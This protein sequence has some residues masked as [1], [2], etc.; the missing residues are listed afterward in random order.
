MKTARR[1]RRILA[2]SYITIFQYL[3]FL[4]G[5]PFKKGESRLVWRNRCVSDWASKS[6]RWLG[7]KI[8]VEGN[9]PEAPFFLV[10]NHLSYIDVVPLYKHLDC[11]FVAMQEVKSWPLIGRIAR[12]IG[13]LFI[14]REKIM[15]VKRVNEMISESFSK[16]QGIVIFPEAGTSDGISIS[17]FRS[18]LL[19]IPASIE[20][21][22]SYASLSY[23]TGPDDLPATESVCWSGGISFGAHVRKLV[24]NRSITCTLRFGEE[25]VQMSDRKLLGQE[26]QKRVTSLYTGSL[27]VKSTVRK[28]L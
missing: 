16:N 20:F 18:A 24:A 13:V 17:P 22:V 27:Q 21:P 9:P 25:T 4:V 19:Q 28:E 15:D 8:N 26:L 2:V 23:E 14:D 11:T 1:I 3:L 7:M 10:C 12:S 6:A 5:R